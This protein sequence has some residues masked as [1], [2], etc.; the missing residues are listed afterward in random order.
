MMNGG[1]Q[2]NNQGRR[3]SNEHAG[4]SEQAVNVIEQ[5][6]QF[7]WNIYDQRLHESGLAFPDYQQA[8]A[9]G[10]VVTADDAENLARVTGLP[11]VEL[12]ET[13]KHIDKLGAQNQRDDY[14]REFND[15][16]R[17]K[18][19][20]Y[21]IK[22]GPAVFHTQGGLNIN[23]RAQVLDHKHQPI[24]NLLAAG[25]AA[26]GVS[27]SSVSGYLS[28]NGLLTAV[29]LGLIAAETVVDLHKTAPS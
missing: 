27:G 19:P 14:G 17:L 16:H 15:A 21:A 18:P 24:G 22:V 11:A 10:A 28:G 23:Q 7:A 4:Y 20:Y 8:V 1:V 6:E 12:L 3:F 29:T 26:C 5:P 2:V 13:L 9:A 25:G